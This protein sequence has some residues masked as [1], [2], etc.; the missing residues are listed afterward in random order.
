MNRCTGRGIQQPSLE[1]YLD[2]E[3]RSF[4]ALDDDWASSIYRSAQH[5]LQ[6]LRDAKGPLR[7]D[8]A[9][10]TEVLRVALGAYESHALGGVG[11]GP[12]TVL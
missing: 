2:G 3:M 8:A 4:H 9:E 7:W 10:A 1:V 12:N 11:I 5:W 6:W